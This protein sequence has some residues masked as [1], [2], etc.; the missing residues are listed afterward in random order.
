VFEEVSAICFG[1]APFGEVGETAPLPARA[2]HAEAKPPRREREPAVKG[3]RVV[4]YRPLFSG[5]AVERVPELDF[6]R[7]ERVV[8]LSPAE[9]KRLGV[10]AGDEVVVRSNGSSVTLRA[11]LD[12]RLR[13][14]VVRIAAEHAQ[15]LGVSVE[16]TPS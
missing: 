2:E 13:K 4:G 6:Q 1:G 15:D 7:P 9:A 5:P 3:L 10:S 8:A 11:R 14:G 16:V 12:E